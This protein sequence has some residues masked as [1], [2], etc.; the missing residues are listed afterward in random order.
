MS[1]CQERHKTCST[2]N[3]VERPQSGMNFG[4][5]AHVE[6]TMQDV[7]GSD[8]QQQ[9]TDERLLRD[10]VANQDGT[11][12]AAIMRRHGGMVFAL[13]RRVLQGEQDAEDAFQATFL[14]LMRKAAKVNKPKLLGNWLYGVAYR[15]AGKIRHAK[16]R[17]RTREVPMVD[18]PAPESNDDVSWRD[19]RGVLDDEIQHLPSRYRGPF[20]LFY[21]EGKTAEQ[22]ASALGRPRGTILSQL[23]RARE[24]MRGRL[25]YRNLALSAGALAA[26]LERAASSNAAVPERWLDWAMQAQ[27]LSAPGAGLSAQAKWAAHQ[28]LR[29][30]LRRRL[31]TMGALALAVFLALWIGI[32]GHPPVTAPPATMVP[33]KS[34]TDLDGLQGDWQVIAFARNGLSLPK[35]QWPF[36]R[37]EIQ[38]HTM[39]H[40]GRIHR[41]RV[42]FWLHPQQQPKS[43]EIQ[44]RAFHTQIDSVFRN[45]LY[46]LDDDTLTIS[47]PEE[48]EDPAASGAKPAE[49]TYTA[50]RIAPAGP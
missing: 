10:Y 30:K 11:A 27:R 44:T 25:A 33:A 41:R 43:M 46:T 14:I 39:L 28:V 9:L 8:S 40:E 2:S 32:L 35:D 50:R 21:L 24:R 29:D 31:V 34:K 42:H 18:L 12:F 22:V 3:G 19:L 16:M 49:L 1:Q 36:T 37:I 45:V 6:E 48:I 4:R 7:N 26:L 23:A 15:V 17:Q 47:R 20:V 38:D 13:C 5:R